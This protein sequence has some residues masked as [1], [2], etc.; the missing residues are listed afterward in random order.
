MSDRQHDCD[1]PNHAR[2]EHT[3]TLRRLESKLDKLNAAVVGDIEGT[4]GIMER[5][6]VVES[7]LSVFCWA[8]S[9]AAIAL[10]GLVV[11]SLWSVIQGAGK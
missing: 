6:R 4:T 2:Q 5:L 10:I 11:K 8:G 9:V 3:E 1:I 7:K